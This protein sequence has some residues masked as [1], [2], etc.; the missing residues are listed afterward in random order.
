M[1]SAFGLI[2]GILRQKSLADARFIRSSTVKRW[3]RGLTLSF[4]IS[5]KSRPLALLSA[6]HRN[7]HQK[8]FY[9]RKKIWFRGFENS[10]S[11]PLTPP[12]IPSPPNFK[13]ARAA[14]FGMFR[15]NL[16]RSFG[17]H[18]PNSGPMRICLLP[19]KKRKFPEIADGSGIFEVHSRRRVEGEAEVNESTFLS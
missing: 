14:I 7:L 4:L 10:E 9:L 3:L 18:S 12:S 13:S 17:G 16:K 2:V 1:A 15:Q 5:T 8:Y 11:L 6:R 19:P